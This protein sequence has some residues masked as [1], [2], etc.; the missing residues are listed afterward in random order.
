MKK[1]ELEVSVEG[2]EDL[3]RPLIEAMQSL[4]HLPEFPLQ[5]FSDLVTNSLHDLSVG[6]D[7]SALTAGDFRV[8]IRSGRDLEL[9]TA[10][11]LALNAYLH[12]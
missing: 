7:S 6:F 12:R 4:E 1:L 2:V 3:V 5:V 11:L 10:A 8:V 9:I